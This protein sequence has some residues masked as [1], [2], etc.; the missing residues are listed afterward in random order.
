MKTPPNAD[1]KRVGQTR[2]EE[3]RGEVGVGGQRLQRVYALG[4][5]AGATAGAEEEHVFGVVLH[6]VHVEVEK[7]LEEVASA[8]AV[9][10]V[11]RG[12]LQPRLGVRGGRGS[13]VDDGN[14]D[15][16]VLVEAFVE[17]PDLAV[18]CGERHA[19]AVVMEKHARLRG[20]VAARAHLLAH[21]FHIG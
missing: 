12:G 1:A 6:G 21:G 11:E 5:R 9:H 13:D 10:H 17:H 2:G 20:L 15:W 16:F 4:R 18:L 14:Q 8:T 7:V 19:V 3:I